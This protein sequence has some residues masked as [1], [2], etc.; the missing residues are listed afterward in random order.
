M[1]I[2]LNSMLE[3]MAAGRWMAGARIEDAISD[4]KKFNSLG[5]K[6]IINYLGEDLLEENQVN[7]SVDTYM[8]L[9][10]FIK[11]YGARSD[12]S[13][14]PTQIGLSISEGLAMQNYSKIVTEAKSSG[15]FVWL[16]MEQEPTVDS[17][18]NIYNS[19]I[20]TGITGIC[21]QSY[22]KRTES[23]IQKLSKS[24]GVIRLVKGAYSTSKSRGFSSREEVTNNYEKL[25]KL[26]Y[27]NLTQF[28]I[29]THDLNMIKISEEL[30]KQYK[31]NVTYAMLKGI[32]NREAARMA[33]E[34][35]NV[36]LYLP[37]GDSWVSYS[38]RR[39]K[40][41]GHLKLIIKSLLENQSV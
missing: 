40:E 3:K 27:L 10:R 4:S 28:T 19:Q 21:L 7:N 23:D 22:L 39:L 20:N 37:F 32:R 35:N 1:T 16:D 8:R 36:S 9:I 18:I 30:N 14:K 5:I 12:I 13:L 25:M 15:I 2:Q 34:G 26:L 38:Y 31:R 6:T 29:A 41:A 11:N 24:G 17:A 33:S